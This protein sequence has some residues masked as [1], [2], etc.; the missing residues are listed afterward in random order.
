MKQ[1]YLEHIPFETLLSMNKNTPWIRT[2]ILVDYHDCGIDHPNHTLNIIRAL[3]NGL[4]VAKGSAFD[5]GDEWMGVYRD[6]DGEVIIPFEHE[7]IEYNQD[8]DFFYCKSAKDKRIRRIDCKGR[9]IVS[10]GE[11]FYHVS[12]EYDDAND[13]CSEGLIAVHRTWEKEDPLTDEI[14]DAFYNEHPGFR[15]ICFESD[16]IRDKYGEWYDGWGYLD[17][18]GKEVIACNKDFFK[19][20]DFHDGRAWVKGR[21]DSVLL[22]EMGQYLGYINTIGDLSIQISD[23]YLS[24]FYNGVAIVG[25]GKPNSSF[26]EHL[27]CIN[28][29]GEVLFSGSF[30]KI[31]L[32]ENGGAHVVTGSGAEYDVNENWEINL[33]NEDGQTIWIKPNLSRYRYRSFHEGYCVIFDGNRNCGL[34][35]ENGDV[36]VPVVY[37]ILNDFC[38]GIALFELRI[39]SYELCRFRE[40]SP[41]SEYDYGVDRSG[42]YVESGY[43]DSHL[44]IY[45]MGTALPK[46]A[47]YTFYLNNLLVVRTFNGRYGIYSEEKAEFLLPPLYKAID[48]VGDT[49]WAKK[50]DVDFY[51]NMDCSPKM[52]V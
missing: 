12:R 52:I 20:G 18:T 33:K 3:D 11:Q 50:D 9:M 41:L 14:I 25:D 21:V 30:K 8:E 16:E 42:W 15:D 46:E 6:D 13:N 37:S 7:S 43:L 22:A 2:N 44:N 28:T 1:W 24:D 51:F 31:S 32:A 4:I 34:I 36:V 38:N 26:A 48:S 39:S 17:R 35:N 23:R 45:I 27:R 10:D 40:G 49:I 19:V 47:Y 5:D 29:K